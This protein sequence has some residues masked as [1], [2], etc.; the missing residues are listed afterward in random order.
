MKSTRLVVVISVLSCLIN[1][2]V[3]SQNYFG[4]TFSFPNNFIDL[5]RCAM[6]RKGEMFLAGYPNAML[7]TD[8]SGAIIWAK[9]LT[10]YYFVHPRFIFPND[11]GGCMLVC[12]ED[13]SGSKLGGL[14]FVLLSDSGSVIWSKYLKEMSGHVS[15]KK[16]TDNGYIISGFVFKHHLRSYM[17]KVDSLI[18]VQWTETLFPDI[19][20]TL[21]PELY[22]VEQSA[23]GN[24]YGIG[25]IRDSNYNY[26]SFIWSVNAQGYSLGLKY[27]TQ[28]DN[29]LSRIMKAPDGGFILM[30]SF[31]PH[32]VM[33]DP[34]SI[35]VKVDSNF[36]INWAVRIPESNGFDEPLDY[37]DN[38]AID[39]S[40]SIYLMTGFKGSSLYH[41]VKMDSTGSLVYARRINLSNY[42]YVIYAYIGFHDNSLKFIANEI[43]D[44]Y[45]YSMPNG[46]PSGCILSD[47]FASTETISL[48]DSFGIVSHHPRHVYDSTYYFT[49]TSL[50]FIQSSTCYPDAIEET[51]SKTFSIY[52]NPSA[53][54]ISLSVNSELVNPVFIVSMI[55]MDGI[56]IERSKKDIRYPIDISFLSNGFYEIEIMQGPKLFRQKLV[57]MH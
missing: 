1:L 5:W 26:T 22:Q 56:V 7:K 17:L 20:K 44:N 25:S 47:V 48:V 49:Q 33:N 19:P 43:P 2:S 4:T 54:S 57:V 15:I 50:P 40:G 29:Q 39:S 45:I 6:N 37:K 14:I 13:G 10:P 30:G 18:N 11:S 35:V 36:N 23:S 16:T 12:S 31:D 28:L 51:Q 21:V 9:M 53:G 38:T 32:L 42:L 41:L 8:S 34:N 52:P 55:S 24:Y 46:S 3:Y 27:F